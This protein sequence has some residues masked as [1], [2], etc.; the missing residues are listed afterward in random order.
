MS[1][2][3]PGPS[4]AGTRYDAVVL[5]GGAA[6]RLGGADKPGALVGG[7]SLIARVAAAAAAA[8][9]LIIVGPARPE[10][11]HALVVREDPP[12]AGPVPA[13]RAGMAAVRAPWTAL[14]AADLPFLRPAD[15][16]GLF[17]AARGH[18]GAVLTDTGGHRQ[19]LA[20]VWRSD[21]LSTALRDYEGG[22]LRGLLGPLEPA[23][24]APVP[25]ES[26][27]ESTEEPVGEPPAW[28]DCDTPADLDLAGR[29]GA[30]GRT[31]GGPGTGRGVR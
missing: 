4:P 30:P 23:L 11:P 2:S 26:T 25:G 8:E 24:V 7:R 21:V 14:L 3:E 5:A 19:W 20:G 16:T 17:E 18:A 15:L 27:G 9:R 1:R 12:G 31:T 6:R 13:L 10:L 29:L 28:F 22:S